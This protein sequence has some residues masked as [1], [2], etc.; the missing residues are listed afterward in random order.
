MVEMFNSLPDAS[1]VTGAKNITI[2]G[3]P[4]V[5]DGTLTAADM[6]IATNKGYTLTT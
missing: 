4:C 6:A 2:T 5:T 1:D 3:N